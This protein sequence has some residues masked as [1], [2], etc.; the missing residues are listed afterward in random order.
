VAE[1]IGG[2]ALIVAT[3]LLPVALLAGLVGGPRGRGTRWRWQVVARRMRRPGP[4]EPIARRPLADV[5]ADASRIAG[6]FHREGMRFAQYEGRRKAFDR[7]L[8][9]AADMVEVA[10]LL[11]VLPPGAALDRERHRVETRLVEAG[12]LPRHPAEPV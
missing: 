2:L 6:Q 11:D 10:H 7:V 12:L 5:A 9:E 8:G 1:L 4:P 3:A